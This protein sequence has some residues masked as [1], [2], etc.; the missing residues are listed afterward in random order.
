MRIAA[1][2]LAIALLPS[3][4]GGAPFRNLG[5][6]EV[7]TNAVDFNAGPVSGQGSTGELLPGWQ[8]YHGD[9]PV[10]MMGFNFLPTTG[11]LATV[12]NHDPQSPWRA[13]PPIDGRYGLCL[14]EVAGSEAYTLIQTGEIP[15]GTRFLSYF[16]IQNPMSLSI[17]GE[18]ITPDPTYSDFAEQVVRDVSRFAGKE[19]E[20]RLTTIS[21]RLGAIP[22]RSDQ[23]IGPIA[24]VVPEPAPWLLLSLGG[25]GLAAYGKWRGRKP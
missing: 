9:T 10:T 20:L 21:S 18:A 25:L 24:F 3:L 8:L 23:Y 12:F 6:D 7:N 2:A 5:F 14:Q 15:E 13:Y 11:D 17:N 4:S 22:P 1:I 19:V 16:F